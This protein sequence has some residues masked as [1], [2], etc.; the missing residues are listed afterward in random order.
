[1]G[2]REE[3]A[4]TKNELAQLMDMLKKKK[5]AVELLEKE[6]L[7]E[8]YINGVT[9]IMQQVDNLTAEIQGNGLT[10]FQIVKASFDNVK[11][12]LA[13]TRQAIEGLK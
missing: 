10:G 13:K 9:E 7:N 8:R 12:G 2:K 3:L 6:A 4:Q 5:E 11:V 1:M